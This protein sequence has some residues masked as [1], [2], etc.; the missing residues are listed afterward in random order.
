MRS[1][2]FL[3]LLIIAG[4]LQFPC[5]LSAQDQAAGSSAVPSAV[6]SS[7]AAPSPQNGDED[8]AKD[9]STEINVKDADIAAIIRIFSKK[10]KRNY[11]LDERVKGK[12]SI[13]LPG[14]VTSDE[15]LRIL[16]SVLA[17]KGFTSV[18]IGE[19][20]WKIVPSKEAKQSTIPVVIDGEKT[21]GASP[22]VVTRLLALKYVNAEDVQQLLSQLISP[23]GLINAYTG[24]NSLIVVD[25]EDNINKLVEIVNAIDV[26]SSD[27]DMSI[28]PIKYAEAVSIA[29]KLNEIL[30]TGGG[31]DKGAQGTGGSMDLLRQ[32][33]STTAQQMP[34]QPGQPGMPPQAAAPTGGTGKT[35]SARAKEPKITA[36]ERTNSVIVVADEDTTARVKALISQLDTKNNLSGNKFY[37]YKCEHAKADEL[38][39]VLAGLMGEGGGTGMTGTR[40]DNRRYGQ[41]GQMGD[42]FDD[43]GMR[44]SSSR[45]SSS[46]LGGSS[47]SFGLSG[48][49]SD[50]G[51]M[52]SSSRSNRTGEGRG[53]S[54][55]MLGENI[56]VT[57]DPA[58]NTLIIVS[59]KSDYEKIL[60][61]LKELDVKRRQVIVEAMLLE[62]G[63]D[64][65]QELGT[66]FLTSGGGADGG[67]F[68]EGNFGTQNLGNLF[69]NPAR[70]SG[71]TAAA[72][73]SGTLTLPNGTVV[74]SQAILVK[75]AS[76]LSNVNVLSAPTILA[77]D[78]EPAKIL[79]GTNVPFLASTSTSEA[80]LNNTFNQVDRQDVG[81]S[82]EMTPQISSGSYVTLNLFTEVSGLVAATLKDPLGPT[83]TKRQSE[84][85]IIA[86]DGQMIVI[87]GLL[88]DDQSEFKD[89]VPYLSEVP[90][91][92]H[93][94]RDTSTAQKRTNLLIFITPR[95][96]K[97]QYDVREVTYEQ[98]NQ[99]RN[100]IHTNEVFP[101]REGVL[102][103]RRLDKV[104]ELEEFKGEAP[105]TILPKNDSEDQTREAL[106]P[107]RSF[108]ADSPGVIEL[109]VAPKLPEV[110]G[111]SSGRKNSARADIA[112]ISPERL[113]ADGSGGERYVVM[114]LD[115]SAAPGNVPFEIDPKSGA[116]GL[117]V[118]AEA[119]ARAREF[120]RPGNSYSYQMADQRVA[121]HAVGVFKSES[122]AASQYP[123]LRG[124]WYTLSPFEIMGIGKGPWLAT[125][126]ARAQSGPEKG[127]P[128]QY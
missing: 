46:R 16:D 116:F 36:D 23:D 3:P 88:S 68:A 30:G 120:F 83:T 55:V 90:V 118:P 103:S 4:L 64:D 41:G 35:V 101:D 125:G 98:R 40:R 128:K 73:S 20:L 78:N 81:I 65:S 109:K 7:A 19:N 121:A 54:S 47:N 106:K 53:P 113:N 111:K 29:D 79:V 126:G 25:S 31:G 95:I 124:R 28:I 117:I 32:R 43:S 48:S 26:P 122:D 15:S 69:D 84:T 93:L 57:A 56:S 119:A 75:A 67:Y 12:V 58:T 91:L 44:N 5:G 92:G 2:I 10:T 34:V 33:G 76:R 24:T 105:S 37:V 14:K 87:G 22:A 127:Y 99:M 123:S 77:T 61:L 94:F 51:R 9:A 45:S 110:P 72:A 27:R 86:K 102:G 100:D 89:G 60:S 38:A 97:D 70:L 107:V 49:S 114:E 74:P 17:L 18:P 104:T 59:S 80:N 52:G 66:S 13:Y 21:A 1:K 39:N 50:R 63:V 82:L 85:T 11:I 108:S 6:P 42:L 112:A 8:L 62:V 115:S 96:V 71:F